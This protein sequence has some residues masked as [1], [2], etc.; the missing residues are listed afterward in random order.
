[1]IQ[2]YFKGLSRIL[3]VLAGIGGRLRRILQILPGFYRCQQD[4]VVF[5]VLAGFQR[6]W[7]DYGGLCWILQIGVRIQ[8]ALA[9]FS[10]IVDFCKGQQ[11]FKGLSRIQWDLE[12]LAGFCRSQQEFRGASRI[13]QDL[14]GLCRAQLDYADHSRILEVL[15]QFQQELLGLQSSISVSKVLEVLAGFSRILNFQEEFICLSRSQQDFRA[16][17]IQQDLVVFQKQDLVGVKGLSRILDVL[18]AQLDFA[19][20]QRCQ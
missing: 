12:V 4:L 16:L 15:V 18:A 20:I 11:G 6:S 13:Q 10:R 17:R 2:N 19:G 8:W 9:G 3:E 14:V 7:W 5:Q 1:M